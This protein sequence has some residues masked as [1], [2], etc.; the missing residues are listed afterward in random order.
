MK[1]SFSNCLFLSLENLKEKF[2][3]LNQAFN[4]LIEFN[5]NFESAIVK[6][7]LIFILLFLIRKNKMILIIQLIKKK[8]KFY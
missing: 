7:Y 6:K 5:V 1:N 8:L 3:K 2:E 4:K